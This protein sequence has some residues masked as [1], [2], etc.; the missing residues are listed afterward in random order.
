MVISSFSR[1]A[2]TGRFLRRVGEGRGEETHAFAKREME[3][4]VRW[5]LIWDAEKHVMK[6]GKMVALCTLAV[7]SD[8][9]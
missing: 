1:L 9:G 2:Q 3:T 7:A 4:L 6:E 8:D 5:F